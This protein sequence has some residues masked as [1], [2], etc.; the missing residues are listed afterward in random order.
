MFK[1]IAKTKLLILTSTLDLRLP[2]GCTSAWWYLFKAL[3]ELDVDLL[4]TVYQGRVVP[5]P[6]WTSYENPCYWEGYIFAKLKAI[7]SQL[8]QQSHTME[9]LKR[10][11]EFQNRLELHL[12][13]TFIRPR[14]R[15]HILNILQKNQGVDAVLFVNVPFNQLRGIPLEIRNNYHIPVIGYDPDMPVSLPGYGGFA[16]GF[17]IYEDADLQEY[18]LFIGNSKGGIEKLKQMGAKDVQ[19][20]GWSVDPDIIKP[21]A[22]PQ[23]N[24]D[25]FFYGYGDE[26]RQ[27]WIKAMLVDPSYR[28]PG[29][30][31]GIRGSGF[32]LNLGKVHSIKDIP[33]NRLR[34]LCCSS[35]INV[36]IGRESHTQVYGSSSMRPFELAAMECCM[37]SNPYL[38]LEEWFEP[39]QEM[40]VLTRPEEVIEL[41][42]WLWSHE[43]QRHKIGKKARER[44]LKEHTHRH[45]ARQLLEM[46]RGLIK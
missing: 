11:G 5:S 28:W 34:E 45:R 8:S 20:L 12:A 6:F 17:R 46:V 19:F 14:W 27:D 15:E 37:V 43:E 33:I 32:K 38:G 4:V 42:T 26:Y 16:T 39:E 30:F 36:N 21:V 13:R 1:K 24:I 18:D 35:K 44:V 10:T 3:Y 2:Y 7:K 9:N 25:V 31:F 41:Y 40:F 22:V 29:K 23:Q